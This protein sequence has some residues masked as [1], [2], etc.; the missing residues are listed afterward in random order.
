M[1]KMVQ[2]SLFRTFG[3]ADNVSLAAYDVLVPVNFIET[4]FLDIN[5][6]RER[7]RN[8]GRS[9]DVQARLKSREP[10]GPA[11]KSRA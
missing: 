11:V 2:L 10:A 9:S 5:F 8:K 4:G 3:M 6:G 7:R 1:Q